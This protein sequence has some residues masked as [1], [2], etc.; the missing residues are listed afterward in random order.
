MRAGHILLVGDARELLEQ[1]HVKGRGLSWQICDPIFVQSPEGQDDL[2]T[3]M[4]FDGCHI[5]HCD[6]R[7]V[8]SR[9]FSNA[10]GSDEGG[11]GAGAAAAQ[12]LSNVQGSVA[13]KISQDG[14]ITE[15]RGGRKARVYCG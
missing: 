10:I 8:A 14:A 4:N 2:N 3:E 1:G 12:F 11:G 9:F 7:I 6:G 5:I 15:Y 13:I